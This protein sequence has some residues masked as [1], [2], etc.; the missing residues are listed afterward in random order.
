MLFAE[1][2]HR[3]HRRQRQRD[4]GRDR[5]SHRDRDSEF[6][7]NAADDSAHQHQWDE[8]RDQ[9]QADRYDG[10]PDLAGAFERRFSGLKTFL[11][12]ALDIFQHDDGVVDN[13]ANGDRLRPMSDRLSRLKPARYIKAKVP[14]SAKG[15][16]TLGIMVAERLRRNRKIT[17]TTSAMVNI[18]VNCT[19][20]T[21]ARIVVVRSLMMS[22]LNSRRNRGLQLRQ[23]RLDPVNR[24]DHVGARLLQNGENYGSL[25]VRPRSKLAAFRPI[26]SLADIAHAHRRA[27]LVGDDGVVPRLRIEQLV[28][29]IDRECAGCTVDAA[30]RA[31]GRYIHDRGAQVFE[32]KAHRGELLRIDLDAYRGLLLA[33]RY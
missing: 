9:R 4:K 29:V 32:T 15:T 8:H 5:N 20:L 28:I 26:N 12:V 14:T 10:E 2:A 3:H 16:V 1:K 25:V 19:S 18:K 17:K 11:D 31:V 33:D 7:K 13:K 22:V 21:E 30:L 27:V 23:H 24:F 6:A